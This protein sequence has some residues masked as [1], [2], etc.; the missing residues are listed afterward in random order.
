MFLVVTE[1]SVIR[2]YFLN[3]YQIHNLYM[4]RLEVLA[5][6]PFLTRGGPHGSQVLNKAREF[7]LVTF[8]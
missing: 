5:P 2:L 6:P 4:A 7:T 1:I 3:F 8:K